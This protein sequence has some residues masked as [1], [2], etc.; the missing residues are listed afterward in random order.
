MVQPSPKRF[1]PVSTL[2]FSCSWLEYFKGK[3]NPA[4]HLPTAWPFTMPPLTSD[5]PLDKASGTTQYNKERYSHSFILTRTAISS[6]VSYDIT[7]Y[8]CRKSWISIRVLQQCTFFHLWVLYFFNRY[9]P[10]G[11]TLRRNR[12]LLL[13]ISLYYHDLRFSN[14]S[15]RTDL[16]AV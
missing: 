9:I 13:N 8:Y 16:G 1:L 4:T 5:D 11:K 15:F 7:V 12:F 2:W 10:Y 14:Q 3:Q 6:F